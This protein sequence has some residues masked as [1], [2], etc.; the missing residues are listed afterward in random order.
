MRQNSFPALPSLFLPFPLHICCT[1]ENPCGSERG[2]APFQA[3]TLHIFPPAR[4]D[5][6]NIIKTLKKNEEEEGEKSQGVGGRERDPS[7]VGNK[8]QTLQSN[9]NPASISDLSAPLAPLQSPLQLPGPESLRG[10]TPS[11][12]LPNPPA[13]LQP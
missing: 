12:P 8:S 10:P 3:S 7:V 9:K 2:E 1:D 6:R 4:V 11:A 13:I 5:S